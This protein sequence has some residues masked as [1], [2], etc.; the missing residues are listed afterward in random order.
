MFIQV[1]NGRVTN[2]VGLQRQN[3]RWKS[4]LR[5]GASGFLG[6]TVGVTADGRFVATARFESAEAAQRNSNR[7]EQGAWWA[8]MEQCVSNVEFHD[9]DEVFALHGGGSDSAGF[10]QVIRG[11]IVDA[12]AADQLLAK[13]S[14]YEPALRQWRPDVLGE[15]VVRHDDGSFT[16]VVYFSSEADARRGEGQEAPAEARRFL[17]AWNAAS[18]VTDYYDLEELEL[19]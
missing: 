3:E 10:V 11:R 9:S 4:E 15:L 8:E 1:I 18:E 2:R 14:D 13:L 6:S 17:D 16:L 5:P 19:T 12:D 7:P